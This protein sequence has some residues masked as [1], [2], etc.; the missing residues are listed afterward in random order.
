MND[1]EPHLPGVITAITPQKRNKDRYSIFVDN[2]F[3]LGISDSTLT[4]RGLKKG[5]K[6]TPSLYQKLQRDEGRNA[7]KSYMLKLLSRREHARRELFNKARNKDYHADV[8]ND[9]LDELQ[10]KDLVNEQ[11]FANTYARDKNNLNRWGP[12]KIEAHLYKKG[13]GKELAQ[14]AVEK[15]FEEVDLKARFIQLTEK[16]RRRFLRE[17]DTFK[18][19]KKVVDYLRRKGYRPGSIFNYLDELMGLLEK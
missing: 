19:K 1:P 7:V 8:I 17:E 12:S 10:K 2:A 6:L 5:Q 13:I 9:V 14:K 16:K 4:D 15:A 18:R 11:R 3:V